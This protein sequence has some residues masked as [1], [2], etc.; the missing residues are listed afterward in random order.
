M[1]NLGMRWWKL[2]KC[3]FFFHIVFFPLLSVNLEWNCTYIHILTQKSIALRDQYL[4]LFCAA[5]LLVFYLLHLL[6]SRLI[7]NMILCKFPWSNSSLYLNVYCH[8]KIEKLFFVI[9]CRWHCPLP[10]SIL[11]HRV[12]IIFQH[13]IFVK[14]SIPCVLIGCADDVRSP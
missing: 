10:F 14:I 2:A 11:V 4:F 7:W 6:N 13:F 1:W 9:F 12:K 3:V 5:F 8:L